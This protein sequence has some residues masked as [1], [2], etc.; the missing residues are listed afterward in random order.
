MRADLKKW[1][2]GYQLNIACPLYGTKMY[3]E[4]RSKGYLR[5]FDDDHLLYNNGLFLDTPEFSAED[6]YEIYN[7]SEEK[8]WKTYPK[9]KLI[10]YALL[11]PNLMIQYIL[12]ACWKGK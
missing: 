3:T 12:K 1:V 10:K 2:L 7:A 6:V 9:L 4:A 8:V 5:E 11:N